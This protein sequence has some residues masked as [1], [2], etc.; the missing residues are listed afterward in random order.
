MAFGVPELARLPAIGWGDPEE[1]MSNPDMRRPIE[2]TAQRF[3]VLA[4]NF[5]AAQKKARS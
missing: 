2:N 5:E 3:A 4:A 1:P